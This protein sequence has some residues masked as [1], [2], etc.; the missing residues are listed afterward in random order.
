MIEK[1]DVESL[2][3]VAIIGMSGRFPGANNIE[4]YWDNIKNAKDCVTLFSKEE[5]REAGVKEEDLN[6]N[7][8]V[9][10]GGILENVEMFD[11]G[12]FGFNPREAENMDPQ[13]RLFLECSYEA[14]EDSGYALDNYDMPVGVYSGSNMST[15]F[16]Y[17]LISKVGVKDDFS[18][19][20]LNDKDYI[21][22]RVSYEFNLTGP[23]MSVQTAC[24]T[25]MTAVAMAYEGLLNYQCD[26]ALA[27]GVAV[28]LPQKMG[29]LYQEG[30]IASPDG[31][32]RAFDENAHGT[33][34]SSA[35]GV[36]VLKRLEDAIRDKDNIYAVIKGVSVNN[37]GAMKVGFTAPSPEGQAEVIAAAMNLAGVKPEDV[38]YIEAHGT[39]TSLGDPIEIAALTQVFRQATKRKSYCAIGSVKSN[40]GHPVSAAGVS[41]LIK[42]AL[43][44]YNKQLPPSINFSAPNPKINIEDSPFYINTKLRE[45]KAEGRPRIAGVSSFGFGGT[46]VHAVLEEAP[47]HEPKKSNGEYVLLT[48]SAKT[49]TA[50]KN[51]CLNLSQ[52]LNGNT[53]VNLNDVAYTLHVGRREFEFRKAIVCKSAEEA[54][55]HLLLENNKN[56]F[57]GIVN[58]KS[59][60]KDY[61]CTPYDSHKDKLL[62]IG[63][64]WTNGAK[65]DWSIIHDGENVGR[66]SLP[67]YPFDKK[68]YWVEQGSFNQQTVGQSPKLDRFNPYN[69]TYLPS[70]KKSMCMIFKQESLPV[71]EPWIVF[72]GNN[73]FDKKLICLLKKYGVKVIEVSKG[74]SFCQENSFSYK[75]NYKDKN[76][77][78]LLWNKITE[79]DM[80]PVQFVHL[81]GISAQGQLNRLE[82]AEECQQ[83]GF[84]S[85]LYLAQMLAKADSEKDNK[86]TVI[87]DNMHCISG[88]TGIYPE[89]AT[90]LGPCKVIPREIANISCRCIDIRISE[91]SALDTITMKSVLT[92]M[93]SGSPEFI[94]ALRGKSRWI[95]AVEETKLMDSVDDD[96]VHAGSTYLITG[97]LGGIGIE[98]AKYMATQANINLILTRRSSFPNK[99]EW[100]DWLQQHEIDNEISQKIIKLMEIEKL[101]SKVIAASINI[102]DFEEMSDFVAEIETTLGPIKGVIHAAGIVDNGL[103]TEKSSETAAK[104]LKPKLIGTIVLDEIFRKRNLDFMLLFSSSSAILGNAG[105]V[106]YCAANTF[107]DAYA[108]SNYHRINVVSIDWDEWEDIG[109]AAG[110]SKDRFRNKISLQSGLKLLD[111]IIS[112]QVGPQIVVSPGDLVDMIAN[113]RKYLLSPKGCVQINEARENNRP[114]LQTV[115]LEPSN[116]TQEMIVELWQN[117]LGVFPVGVN[118]DF[119][120][121]GGDSLL[122]TTLA[123]ELARK[124]QKTVSLQNLFERTTISSLAEFFNEDEDS[125]EEGLL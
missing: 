3:G 23:S 24:S 69:W 21:A 121:L 80:Q 98:M 20:M 70:W 33:I 114:E 5:A 64:E 11:A 18:L 43:A 63:K 65:I 102:C 123:S 124:F 14:L 34:F 59:L 109:M 60:R 51:M 113:I 35:V 4:E 71:S 77:Y 74:I 87:T 45:W 12:F 118:D 83:S 104:V 54:S 97:G 96:F 30:M 19:A 26:M 105:F 61:E 25:S 111:K 85:L 48:L 15:Y 91:N 122:A 120:D 78:F 94:V 76:D 62:S 57:S 88:E 7:N 32:T 56:I 38:D 1:R 50:L 42:T 10:V 39:G 95:Q 106:D 44:L 72:T 115:Y 66:I 47:Q 16:L 125:Y 13:Q 52:Y 92:E 37:D 9:F 2:E 73:D 29:Y 82:Y 93:F 28:K 101:G 22:T 17:N 116:S 68:K 100:D 110:S 119:F 103:I 107:L 27:G 89:K 49:E 90:V 108:Q 41:G 53:Q 79:Q 75:I 81:W 36:V 8:Y 31:H 55:G 99:E 84:Y 112:N 67:T 58:E 40:I 6:D 117:L 46:N 86:I